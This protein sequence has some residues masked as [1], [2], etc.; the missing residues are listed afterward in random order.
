[1]TAQSLIRRERSVHRTTA[2][3]RA[4]LIF[5]SVEM[6]HDLGGSGLLVGL[7]NSP[8]PF[9]TPAGLLAEYAITALIRMLPLELRGQARTSP[10]QARV[11]LQPSLS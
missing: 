8:L 6:T 3:G 2:A 4:H 9:A 10:C 5:R 1:M 7:R 11:R